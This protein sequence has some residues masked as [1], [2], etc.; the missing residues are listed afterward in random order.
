GKTMLMTFFEIMQQ[1]YGREDSFSPDAKTKRLTTVYL[2]KDR[3]AEMNIRALG[4][5]YYRV[6]SGESTGWN[7]FSLPATKRNINFIK[8]LMKILCTRNGSTIS[9]RDER[10]LS[11]A[12][13][14]VMN[15][16]PQYRVY[17]ITRM[18]ENLPEPATKEAQENGLS[19]RL[20]QWAQGGEFGWVFD[21]ESDTFDIS[22]CDNFGIDGT[23]FLD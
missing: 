7:P 22:N 15:D 10:R 21:N 16:E 19:I 2:D 3:G 11:D 8:Q 12:V 17:G 1:K 14:A 23:E 5:R 18:L 6:I 4:G 13:N 9:P 20:S